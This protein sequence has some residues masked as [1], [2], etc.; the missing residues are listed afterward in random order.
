MGDTSSNATGSYASGTWIG[1][2]ADTTTPS[3]ASTTL[4]GE[5]TGGT[6]GRAQ[7]TYAHT[8]GAA[9]YTLTRNF[10]SDRNVVVAK[11]GVFNASSGGTLCFETLLDSTA[12]LKSG[13]TIQIV[14]TV[15]L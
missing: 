8:N 10:T 6:M 13:D 15:T 11:L 2:S 14:E 4:T 12:D 5:L 9:S 1:I 7:A 3:T